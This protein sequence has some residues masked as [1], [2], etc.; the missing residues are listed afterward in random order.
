MLPLA[1]AKHAGVAEF[2]GKAANGTRR[3]RKP[4]WFTPATAP[5]KAISQIA[6]TFPS[7]MRRAH[8][9]SW[10]LPEEITWAIPPFFPSAQLVPVRSCSCPPAHACSTHISCSTPN[11]VGKFRANP[12]FC[13]ACRWQTL[14]IPPLTPYLSHSISNK[15]RAGSCR[16]TCLFS[17]LSPGQQCWSSQSVQPTRCLP[18]GAGQTFSVLEVNKSP[19]T[20]TPALQERRQSPPQKRLL[21]TTSL[22][23]GVE[24]GQPFLS[25]RPIV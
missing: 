15:K 14:P 7:R 19:R 4:S 24:H 11:E 8:G 5:G 13:P 3:S 25:I 6:R 9:K 16:P 12:I 17:C 23:I 21:P 2:A 18:V 10:T 1:R 22:N 20:P